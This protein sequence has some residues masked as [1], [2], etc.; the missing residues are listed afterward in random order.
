MK[1]TALQSLLCNSLSY[2]VYSVRNK[3]CNKKKINI[4]NFSK[5]KLNFK[6]QFLSKNH[7]FKIVLEHISKNYALLNSF[8]LS[9]CLINNKWLRFL[10]SGLRLTES[11]SQ[12]INL[13]WEKVDEKYYSKMI[14]C[15]SLTTVISTS[16]MVKQEFLLFRSK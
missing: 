7:V 10:D 12:K 1:Y 13:R 16:V 2:N 15:A 9:V 6:R 8:I 4:Y 14:P 3:L 11:E 5:E